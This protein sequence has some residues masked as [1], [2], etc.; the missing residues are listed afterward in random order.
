[1]EEGGRWYVCTDCSLKGM[2]DLVSPI[3]EH[4]QQ[5]SGAGY[6]DYLHFMVE[7]LQPKS[8]S[9]RL[10][11]P[12][13]EYQLVTLSRDR[14]LRLWPISEQLSSDL[15]AVVIETEGPREEVASVET[16]LSSRS[17]METETTFIRP[18][19]KNIPPS[20]SVFFL[21]FPSFFPNPLSH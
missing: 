14:T 11:P 6:S 8:V 17:Q 10:L 3:L 21:F 4:V 1:M 2:F 15:G 12:Y 18:Q 20:L 7:H 19:V 5:Y 9:L 13:S 16:S